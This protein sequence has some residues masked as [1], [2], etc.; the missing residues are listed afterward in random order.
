MRTTQRL[1]ASLVWSALAIGGITTAIAEPL[2]IEIASAKQDYDPHNHAPVISFVM[3]PS[4]AR[5]FAEFTT[6]SLGRKIAIRIDGRVVM[7]LVIREPILGGA[8]QIAGNL[9]VERAREI[10]AGLASGT[11]KI[12]M[13]IAPE[14]DRGR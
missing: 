3:T 13:E 14:S 6:K 5:A 4:S 12:D 8:G 2:Q 10:A 1:P 11:S 9:T 7:T